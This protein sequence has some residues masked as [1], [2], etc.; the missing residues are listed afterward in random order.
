MVKFV[1]ENQYWSQEQIY[2]YQ[3][4]CLKKLVRHAYEHVAYYRKTMQSMGM[5]PE[6]FKSIND[7]TQ[8]PV[9][10][11]T[12][13]I[14]ESD[15][16]M[17]SNYPQYHP[18]ERSTGGT[19][20]IPFKYY[21]DVTSWGLNWATKIRTFSWGGYSFGADK[22][23]VLKG[24][25][26]LGK[27]DFSPK[28]HFWKYLHNYYTI[29]IINMSAES[30]DYHFD[31]IVKRKIRFI[32][33]FPSALFVFAKHLDEKGIYYPMKA[34]FTSAEM[35]Y[36]YQRQSIERVFGNF[37]ID[38]YGCG[39]GMAGANQCEEHQGYHVN[40]ETCFMEILDASGFSVSPGGQGDVTVTSLH[41]YAMPL[42]RY[43]PGDMAIVANDKCNCGRSL[44]L[45]SKINGRS[46]DLFFLPNGRV[47]NGLSIPFEDWVDKIERFQLIHE[48]PDLVVLKIIPKANFK[49]QDELA[50]R[51]LLTHNIGEGI[52]IQIDTVD[53]IDNTSAGKFRYIISKVK[54]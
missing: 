12:E 51:E 4:A 52:S 45:L 33:G 39:D 16:F 21:N 27:G 8:F 13:I 14:A 54:Q 1:N 22:I 38:A 5:N 9:I 44:P 53:F 43:K 37:I 31:Q 40:I 48:K 19:T 30:I 36:E 20:G 28:T 46:A 18:M 7:L 50:I 42:I 41:D 10:S 2:N 32:R 15:N 3:F 24:G 23:A 11:K 49:S 47:L 25:S 29:P 35:L 34:I 17:A 6:D 26:M